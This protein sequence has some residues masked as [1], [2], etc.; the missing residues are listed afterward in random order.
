LEELQS[1]Y[2]QLIS[3]ERAKVQAHEQKI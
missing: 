2:D 3:V 1:N